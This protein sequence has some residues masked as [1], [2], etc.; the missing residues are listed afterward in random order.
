[1][2]RARAGK[3]GGLRFVLRDVTQ[4]HGLMTLSIDLRPT[5]VSIA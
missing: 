3:A 5:P 2:S 1:M 4:K